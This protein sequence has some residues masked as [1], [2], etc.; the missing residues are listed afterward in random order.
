MHKPSSCACC[1][2]NQDEILYSYNI[3]NYKPN[4]CERSDGINCQAL[5]R[6]ECNCFCKCE[7]IR[8][9]GKVDTGKRN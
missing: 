3:L 5:Q 9:K 8:M 7:K 2:R 6:N 1:P 4:K